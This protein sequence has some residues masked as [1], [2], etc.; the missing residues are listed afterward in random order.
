MS[1]MIEYHPLKRLD[2]YGGVQYSQGS[3]GLVSG[4]LHANYVG[5]TIGMRLLF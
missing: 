3:G 1:V 5:P 4:Y 2:I